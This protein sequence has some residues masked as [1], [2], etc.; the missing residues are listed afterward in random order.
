MTPEEIRRF[1]YPNLSGQ[2]PLDTP[3]PPEFG[4]ER[5]KSWAVDAI[6]GM[7]SLPE[8]AVGAV[9]DYTNTGTYNPVPILEAATLPLGTG[10]IAGVPLKAGEAALGAG[11]LRK[12]PEPPL[13]PGLHGISSQ[14]MDY[15]FGKSTRD[16]GTHI[17]QDPNMSTIYAMYDRTLPDTWGMLQSVPHGRTMPVVADIKKPKEFGF[18]VR[19]WTDP[20]LL[21]HVARNERNIP[22]RQEILSSLSK[23]GPVAENFMDV[24]RNKGFDA[25][26]YRHP[27]TRFPEGISDSFMVFDPNKVIPKF[28][29]QAQELIK[30]RGIAKP[31]ADVSLDWNPINYIASAFPGDITPGILRQVE[32]QSPEFKTF[33]S[34]YGGATPQGLDKMLTDFPQYDPINKHAAKQEFLTN[35]GQYDFYE[36]ALYSVVRKDPKF[37]PFEFKPYQPRGELPTDQQASAILKEIREGREYASDDMIKRLKDIVMGK[38][39][40]TAHP[41]LEGALSEIDQTEAR[42]ILKHG[43]GLLS[44]E[45]EQELLKIARPRTSPSVAF[46]NIEDA[47]RG[48]G[49]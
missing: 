47:L 25:L 42:R 14:R 45:A 1:F 36:D 23:P 28:S 15:Q 32:K 38:P 33:M 29:E 2:V 16:A 34:K 11:I 35:P 21:E 40:S 46:K 39:Q 6:K 12:K 8:R 9:S 44:K 24:F 48:G 4:R 20:E 30:S 17:T 26:S 43:S 22:Y 18:A 49:E 27:D 5:P 41:Y 13:T 7:L 37:I 3:A 31:R 19:N 10:A